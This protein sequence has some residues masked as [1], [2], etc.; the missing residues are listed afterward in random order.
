MRLPPHLIAN[1]DWPLTRES[2]LERLHFP[3]PSDADS[4]AGLVKLTEPDHYL[5]YKSDA[6]NALY[7]QITATPAE[8]ERAKLL[9][10]AQ[11]MLATDAVAG[12][13]FQ[14][15]WITIANKKLKGVWKEVPQFENDFSAWS[16]E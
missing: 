10:D 4:D 14:P 5:G 13:L 8:A 11:R 2:G 3:P 1:K 9:G 6:F 16:W 15:Q 7:K 12:F